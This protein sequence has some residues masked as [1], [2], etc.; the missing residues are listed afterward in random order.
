MF[1]LF[2]KKSKSEK[3]E[4][5]YKKLMQEWHDLSSVNRS[6]SDAKFAEAQDIEKQIN[7]LN[8]ETS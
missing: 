8:N 7:Q 4:K 2:K 5:K 1:G 3:L 6:A